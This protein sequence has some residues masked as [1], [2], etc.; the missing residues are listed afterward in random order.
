[1]VFIMLNS[2]SGYALLNAPV[3]IFATPWKNIMMIF[4]C[5]SPSTI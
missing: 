4:Y 3:S 5:L 2:A 1:M